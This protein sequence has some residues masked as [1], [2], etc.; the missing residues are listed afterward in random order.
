MNHDDLT[1]QRRGMRNSLFTLNN[2]DMLQRHGIFPFFPAAHTTGWLS[3]DSSMRTFPTAQHTNASVNNSPASGFQR[4]DSKTH[5]SQSESVKQ[6][7]V[8]SSAAL[9]PQVE[10]AIAICG[11]KTR[12]SCQWFVCVRACRMHAWRQP[13]PRKSRPAVGGSFLSNFDDSTTLMRPARSGG[14]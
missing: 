6:V 9:H 14:P 10:L 2:S 3:W 1:V 12:Q 11:G 7:P 8:H 13:P 4:L 5:I